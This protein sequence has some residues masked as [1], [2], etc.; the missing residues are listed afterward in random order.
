MIRI[1]IQTG[2]FSSL[3]PSIMAWYEKYSWSA[4]CIRPMR[5]LRNSYK[6]SWT[7]TL[8]TPS[9]ST[10][11]LIEINSYYFNKWIYRLNQQLISA[12]PILNNSQLNRMY[13]NVQCQRYNVQPRVPRW[14]PKLLML[15]LLWGNIKMPPV[16]WEHRNQARWCNG[17][18]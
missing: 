8:F 14:A 5:Y 2:S 15:E 4:V 16:N 10:C 18:V 17:I 7:D 9:L 3:M 12:L 11:I 1:V 6:T 13:Q